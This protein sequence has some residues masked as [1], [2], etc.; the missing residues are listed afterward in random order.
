MTAD[1]ERDYVLGTH[2]EELARLGVQHSVWRETVLAC[3]DSAGLRPGSRALDVGA[4]PGY[5]TLDLWQRVGPTGEVVA[6]ERSERFLAAARARCE[7]EGA[8]NVRFH[9]L[10]LMA[11]S[12][13]E[14]GFDLAWCRW[15]ACFVSS[16]ERLVRELARVVKP[17]GVAVFHEYADYATWR[18][19]AKSPALEE[20][21]RRVMQSW[22]D[23]GGEPD[24]GR[25]LPALLAGAGFRIRSAIPRIFC[26][27]PGDPMWAWPRTF[28]HA[29]TARLLELGSIEHDFARDVRADFARCEADPVGAMLTPLVLEIVAERK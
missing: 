29:N 19:L 28:V 4:G 25:V 3:W 21:V 16:P 14:S 22:R 12:I 5:A 15:V 10:D 2:D 13:P 27:R 17:G 23:N 8:K 20:F 26:I 24:I 11:D 1:S 18:T 7:A 6:V 9:S